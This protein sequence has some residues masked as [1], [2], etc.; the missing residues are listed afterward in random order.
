MKK[1]IRTQSKNP[2][3]KTDIFQRYPKV[4]ISGMLDRD[5]RKSRDQCIL[6]KVFLL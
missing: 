5:G 6:S 1:N 3:K 2:L 4:F